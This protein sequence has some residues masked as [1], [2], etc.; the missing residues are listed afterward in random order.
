[1]AFKAKALGALAGVLL[2]WSA[3]AV[4]LDADASADARQMAQWVLA[5]GDHGGRAF[6]VV[7][8]RNARIYV[9]DAQGRLAGSTPVLLGAARGDHSVPGI[10]ERP[11]NQIRPEERTTPAGRFESEPG[12]NLSGEH[13][14][15]FDYDAGLAI[16]RVRPNLASYGARLQRLASGGSDDK[17]VSLGCVVVP[18][19][20]YDEVIRPVLGQGRGV[21][22]VLPETAPAQQTFAGLASAG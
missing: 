16:H 11:L 2:C 19:A 4:E 8:K 10:G 20:F 5:T 3:H 13:I 15:W 12:R 1:M 14:V 9:I 7:D 18:E 6:A 22:Y 21:V 17:R